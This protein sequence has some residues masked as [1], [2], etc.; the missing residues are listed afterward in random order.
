[1]RRSWFLF[2]LSI[3]TYKWFFGSFYQLL[4]WILLFLLLIL[5][6]GL[7]YLPF[8]LGLLRRSLFFYSPFSWSSLRVSSSFSRSWS[9][10][11]A[12]RILFNINFIDILI[13]YLRGIVVIFFKY[14]L[15][16]FFWRL[17]RLYWFRL[18][19]SS[20][21]CSWPT[22]SFWRAFNLF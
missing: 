16:L 20:S 22:L 21:S 5:L 2:I 7:Y 8:T 3:S 6:F 15:L 4:F 19:F 11:W 12:V 17:L 9:F 13:T 14:L 10:L 1:M 18:Q